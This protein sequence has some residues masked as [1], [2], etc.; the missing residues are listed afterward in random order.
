MLLVKGMLTLVPVHIV[1]EEALVIV[2]KGL[3]VTVAV[4]VAP[5]QPPAAA[6]E[7]VTV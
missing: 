1:A 2:G 6:I 5:G 4:A 3:M 7:F